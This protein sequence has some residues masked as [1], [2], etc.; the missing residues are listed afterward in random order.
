MLTIFRALNTL[1][2]NWTEH[3]AS[4]SGPDVTSRGQTFR[5]VSNVQDTVRKLRKP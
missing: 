5:N 4:L 3:K 2:K 1:Q